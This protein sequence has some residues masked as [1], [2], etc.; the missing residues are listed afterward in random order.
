MKSFKKV[1]LEVGIEAVLDGY[2]ISA[3]FNISLNPV[4]PN[5]KTFQYLLQN[6]VI[7]ILL[8]YCLCLFW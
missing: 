4:L 8:F 6:I 3:D 7:T 5:L 2:I 1:C